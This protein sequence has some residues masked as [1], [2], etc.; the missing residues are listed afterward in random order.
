MASNLIPVELDGKQ[1]SL[2][3]KLIPMTVVALICP[4]VLRSDIYTFFSDEG[5]QIRHN[6]LEIHKSSNYLKLNSKR[7]MH[8]S[9]HC[10]TIYNSQD[11]EAT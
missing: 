6:K 2:V 1:H 10:S 7:Y 11:M 5:L 3:G 4:S 9:V 8:P